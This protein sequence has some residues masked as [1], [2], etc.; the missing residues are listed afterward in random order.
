[1][2]SENRPLALVAAGETDRVARNVLAWLHTFPS[3]PVSAIDYESLPAVAPAM[4]LSSIQSAYITRHY[5]CGGYRAEYQF[6]VVYRISPGLSVDERLKADE[7]LNR[8]GEW[9]STGLPNMGDGIRAVKVE[10][11]ALA[12]LLARYEDGDEDHQILMKLTYEVM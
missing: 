9:A 2:D 8:L 10:T 7:L 4:A 6:K 11:A 1:M 12:A 3:L 5:I